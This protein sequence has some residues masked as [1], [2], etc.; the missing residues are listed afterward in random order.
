MTE[1]EVAK[2][3]GSALRPT[4]TVSEETMEQL[5]QSCRQQR[6]RRTRVRIRELVRCQ[7]KLLGWKA[8]AM[9]GFAALAMLALG[10]ELDLWDAEWSL[11]NALFALSAL[12][13][14]TSL[15]G[16]PFL[17]RSSQY[18]MLEVERA[19]RAGVGKPL[20]VRFLLLLAGELALLGVLVLSVNGALPLSLFQL[21]SVLAAAFL[22]ANNELL[23]LM[24]RVRPERLVYWLLPLF[25]GQLLLLRLVK[26][27]EF[28]E[29][30]PLLAGVLAVWMGY[31]C[32]QLAVQPDPAAEG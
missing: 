17:V 12:A 6:P 24:R 7:L 19:A 9:E 25:A 18:R 14:L 21:L 32:A 8:W 22:A 31:Q 23:L 26:E 15:M 2:K 29:G 28:P 4:E 13:M 16:L 3:L 30:L 10:R 5:L 1:R 20:L 11:R 27:P